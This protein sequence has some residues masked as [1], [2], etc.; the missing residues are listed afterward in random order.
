MSA[1]YANPR[2]MFIHGDANLGFMFLF[3]A[4]FAVGHLIASEK[5]PVVT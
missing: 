5:S 3:T 2:L 4:Y 1:W